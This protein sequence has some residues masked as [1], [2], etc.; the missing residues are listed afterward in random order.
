MPDGSQNLD[1]FRI[2]LPE[3]MIKHIVSILPPHPASGLDRVVWAYS[4]SGS[5]SRLFTNS[6]HTRK[7]IRHV[8]SCLLC[9]HDI[10]DI[11]YVLRGCLIAK[12]NV[13]WPAYKLLKVSVSWER[14]YQITHDGYNIKSFT[15]D[16]QSYS[17]EKWVHLFSNG[18][19]ARN[20]ESALASGVVH[21]LGGK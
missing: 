6:E 15:A 18:A 17:N 2:W 4:S 10:D 7:G 1:L 11:L 19:M 13:N 5:F 20:S 21:D 12:E 8:S 16:V 3:K 9:I 14:Q